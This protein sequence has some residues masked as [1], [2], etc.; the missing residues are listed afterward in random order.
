MKWYWFLSKAFSAFIEMINWWF[1][2]LLLLM[3]CITLLICICWI[4][5]A[6]LGW[7]RLGCGEWP[8]W[9]VVGFGL[10]LFCWGFLHQCSLRRLAYS[11]FWRCLC[12]VL[13]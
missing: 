9:Y 1:L 5:P 10:S 7:S 13:G 2:C 3:C 8:F 12:L 11:S 6:C 4:T